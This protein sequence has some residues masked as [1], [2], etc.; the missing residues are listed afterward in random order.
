LRYPFKTGFSDYHASFFFS[1]SDGRRALYAIAYL[2]LPTLLRCLDLSLCNS[3]PDGS[4]AAPFRWPTFYRIFFFPHTARPVGLLGSRA[5]G[6]LLQLAFRAGTG[7]RATVP[8]PLSPSRAGRSSTPPPSP[9]AFFFLFLTPVVFGV[10]GWCGLRGQAIMVS[11]FFS[12][13]V[14]FLVV[15]FFI[16]A[17]VPIKVALFDCKVFGPFLSSAEQP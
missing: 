6:S 7:E 15:F 3:Q 10:A 17:W 14:L 2:R 9:L 13:D 1:F 11:G 16:P 4:K 12:H 5:N 8:Q